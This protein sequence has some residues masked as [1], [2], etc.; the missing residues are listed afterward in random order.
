[1]SLQGYVHQLRPRRESYVPHIDKVQNYISEGK[2][3]ASDIFKRDNK[4]NFIKKAIAGELLDTD[5]NKIPKI[6]KNSDLITHLKSATEKSSEVNDL[7][8]TAFGKSLTK[9]SIDK[10]S[11][12][13]AR[14][15]GKDPK[16][17]DWENIITK[18]KLR[19]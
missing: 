17:A 6:D 9:L 10:P 2:I 11:N 3:D 13:F 5:G 7:I 16:G 8:K 15:S 4:D 18:T 12:G 19:F 14:G 1:M